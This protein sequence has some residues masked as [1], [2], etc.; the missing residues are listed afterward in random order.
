[1][2]SALRLVSTYGWTTAD[3]PVPVP[4]SARLRGGPTAHEHNPLCAHKS[5][6]WSGHWEQPQ[7]ENSTVR[8]SAC[9]IK[10]GCCATYDLF[11]A[12]I[13]LIYGTCGLVYLWAANNE[14][15]IYWRRISGEVPSHYYCCWR[16]GQSPEI[17]SS[18]L[19]A[20]TGHKSFIR[21]KNSACCA[22]RWELYRQF[23]DNLWG[24]V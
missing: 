21:G 17:E 6:Q 1:M 13:Y 8:T 22:F 18:S 2:L 20:Y 9:E 3:A 4:L 11:M 15:I 5:P 7:K 14:F 10:P 12:Q 16:G 24:Y 23:C 19:P